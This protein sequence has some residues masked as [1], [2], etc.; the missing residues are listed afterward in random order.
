[1]SSGFGVAEFERTETDLFESRLGRVFE[2][3]FAILAGEEM[4]WSLRFS[5]S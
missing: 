1:M 4:I 5:E 2:P 3:A